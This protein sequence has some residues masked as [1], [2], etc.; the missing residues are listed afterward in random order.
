[1][2]NFFGIQKSYSCEVQGVQTIG[3][4][5]ELKGNHSLYFVGTSVRIPVKKGIRTEVIKNYS[6]LFRLLYPFG[7]R[8]ASLATLI[9]LRFRLCRQ[10]VD[11]PFGPH[12][13]RQGV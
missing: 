10:D 2:S 11:Y 1:M 6:P 8:P 4:S 3:L 12:S 9:P 5:T 13:F 7:V